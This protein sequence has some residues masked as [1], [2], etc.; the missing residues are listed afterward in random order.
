MRNDCILFGK[1]LMTHDEYMSELKKASVEC[2]KC[3]VISRENRVHA[4][5]MF[6]S[7]RMKYRNRMPVAY[8][9]V[10]R[11]LDALN[12]V[13]DVGETMV[14]S[15]SDASKKIW[16][17]FKSAIENVYDGT[18]KDDCKF[19]DAVVEDFMKIS[20]EDWSQEI[21]EYVRRYICA[22]VDEIDRSYRRKYE[23][24]ESQV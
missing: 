4:Q 10:N 1:E 17:V 3:F 18:E 11:Y 9:Y 22:C 16:A 21:E 15:V 12:S 24:R 5:E 2:W 19:F 7:L 13:L 8:E 23:I 6:S 14:S 20:N